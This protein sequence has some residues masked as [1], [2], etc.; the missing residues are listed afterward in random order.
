MHSWK[1]GNQIF[2]DFHRVHN[3]KRVKQKSKP[4]IWLEA[5]RPRTL[6][7]AVAPVLVGSVMASAVDSFAWLAAVLAFLGALLIQIGANL[8]NDLSDYIR[9]VDTAERVGP[10]RLAQTGLLKPTEL[11]SGIFVVFAAACVVGGFSTI[12]RGWPILLILAASVVAAFA[13]TGGPKPLGYLGFG[14]IMAFLFFGPVAV[15]ATYFLH[16]GNWPIQVIFAGLGPGLL[17]TAILAVN[18]LRDVE[19][20]STA[21]KRT[22][23][24]RFGVS[25]ARFEYVGCILGAAL[26]PTILSVATGRWA[27]ALPFM[28][29]IAATPWILIVL[30]S[31]RPPDLNHALAGTARTMLIHALLFSIGWLIA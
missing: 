29:I 4:A 21:G 12:L 17:A 8:H 3:A 1:S 9:G 19:T 15:S 27:G 30:R 31:D 23:A 25:F 20:D 28:T 13:Y 6:P 5:V 16:T 24:V 10:R 7:A 11:Q 14:D 22:L 18:N 2:P 26:A